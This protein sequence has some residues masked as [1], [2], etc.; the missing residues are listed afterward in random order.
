MST[1]KLLDSRAKTHGSFEANAQLSQAMKELIRVSTTANLS[2]VHR[3]ALDMI[4][5]KISRMVT[6][7]ANVR[8]HAL[9]IAGYAMLI[10]NTLED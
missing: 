5:L 4:V 2:D 8:D 9:D 6:G 1:K 3:E 7:N 10:A